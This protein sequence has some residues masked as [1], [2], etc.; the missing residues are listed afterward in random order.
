VKVA[1]TFSFR[2]PR[3]VVWELL[4]DPEVLSKALPGAQRLSRT[5]E[6]RYEGLM[7][8]GLGP[9]AAEFSLAVT[10]ADKRPPEHFT[11]HIDSKSGLGFARGTAAVDLE[12]AADGGTTMTYRSDLQIGGRIA[13]VGQRVV[14]SAAR[15]MTEKGL[16]A[17]QRALDERLAD[18]KG[19]T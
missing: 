14:D 4:Q 11:M 17:L 18:Q 16:E 12:D 15:A 8:V 7:K 3:R 9:L 6:D 19:H 2:G 10:L 5:S 1:G 13:S